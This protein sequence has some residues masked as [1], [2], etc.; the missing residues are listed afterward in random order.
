MG[1]KSNE[2]QQASLSTT[3]NFGG[4]TRPKQWKPKQWP[5]Y[6]ECRIQAYLLSMRG[7]LISYAKRTPVGASTRNV[8][9]GYAQPTP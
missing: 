9:A 8:P 5:K 3:Q 6:Q 7:V 1:L 2:A 4:P